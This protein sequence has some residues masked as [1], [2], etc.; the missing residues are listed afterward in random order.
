MKW[1]KR[2]KADE[3]LEATLEEL[4]K[5]LNSWDGQKREY[6]LRKA[7]AC[8]LKG[9]I[10]A[11]RAAKKSGGDSRK[12]NVEALG[13]F[14]EAFDLSQKT[15]VEAL[16]YIGH[17]QVRLGDH[18]P[19]LDTFQQLA[20]MVPGPELSLLRARALKFQ[21]E[22]HE[23]RSQPNYT[24][25]NVVLLGAVAVLPPDAALLDKAE[26][27]EMHGRVR[28]KAGIG[29]ATQ[30]Y[31]EA[32]RFYQRIVDGSKSN[33]EEVAAARAGLTRVRGALQRIRLKPIQAAAPNGDGNAPP[34][35][36]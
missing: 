12:D 34:R 33:D 22:V 24:R 26:I 30:S 35:S 5:Q 25:A 17:Q 27:H 4:Q 10:A 14:Q 19:A 18:D 11:A 36:E 1:G 16:E 8:L 23:C 6:E 32:E 7:Q 15:D 13:Y 20:A 9:A 21:A 3:S 28:E 31:T 2:P 29:L